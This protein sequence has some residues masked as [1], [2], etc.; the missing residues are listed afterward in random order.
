MDLAIG[1]SRACSANRMNEDQERMKVVYAGPASVGKTSILNCISYSDCAN[2]RERPTIGTAQRRYSHSSKGRETRIIFW[3]TAGQ[4]KY[5]PMMRSYLRDSELV[6]LV[7]AIDQKDSFNTLDVWISRIKEVVL[8][9]PIILVGNKIDVDARAVSITNELK[10]YHE[11]S[12]GELGGTLSVL[13]SF[14]ERIAFRFSEM[15]CVG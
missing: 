3:D 13:L 6:V 4:E 12:T 8:D 2:A 10:S 11:T 14:D 1:N 9:A 5:A 7:F 15:T